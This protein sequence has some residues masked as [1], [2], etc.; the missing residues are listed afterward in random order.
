MPSWGGRRR[1]IPTISWSAPSPAS[2]RSSAV[3][4][5]PLA[6]VM[7]IRSGLAPPL[8]GVSAVP[9]VP[10]GA[11]PQ[12][13]EPFRVEAHLGRRVGDR[14]ERHVGIGFD[15]AGQRQTRQRHEISSAAGLVDLNVDAAAVDN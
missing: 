1:A 6:P 3:P 8:F 14:I 2:R 11:G 15:D 5:L 4:T 9:A 7:T 10:V 13:G 12:I